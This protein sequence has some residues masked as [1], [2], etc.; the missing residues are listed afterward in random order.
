M[1]IRNQG[2]RA[3]VLVAAARRLRRADGFA[4]GLMLV[5][6][7]AVVGCGSTTTA[8]SIVRPSA[9]PTPAPTPTTASCAV[10]LRFGLRF[11]GTDVTTTPV[12][13]SG[14]ASDG[15][16]SLTTTVPVVN[17]GIGS[18]PTSQLQLNWSRSSVSMTI[19]FGDGA[20]G[21]VTNPV[22]LTVSADGSKTTF[23]RLTVP[24]ALGGPMESVNGTV[25]C[26]H[27]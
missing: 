21:S 19:N 16:W 22:G 13:R 17:A 24:D 3:E 18:S 4:G 23:T 2:A 12:T 10:N 1:G 26:P 7:L 15:Q 27:P 11:P 14:S 5:A 9:T 25:V 20:S 8:S 6:A